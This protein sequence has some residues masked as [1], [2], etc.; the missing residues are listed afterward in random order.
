MGYPVGPHYAAQ[1]NITNAYRLRGKLLLI[2]GELDTNVPPESTLRLAD[3]LIKSSRDFELLLIP[4]MGHSDGG[5]YGERRRRDFFVRHLLGVEPPDWNLFITPLAA[6]KKHAD[7]QNGA[8]SQISNRAT[9]LTFVNTSKQTVKVY[10]LD[11]EGRRVLYQTLKDGETYQIRTYL[12]H[13]WVITD[14]Q[15]RAWAVYYPTPQPRTI[16]IEPPPRK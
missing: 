12:T 5:L 8:H 10:W 13:P 9:S 14:E 3:A 1:S 4:G 15:D 6:D 11:F 7:E 2:V 16:A